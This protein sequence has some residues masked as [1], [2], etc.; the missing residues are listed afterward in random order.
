[1]FVC[2]LIFSCK[3]CGENMIFDIASQSAS[4]PGKYGAIKQ[5]RAFIGYRISVG[6]K[7]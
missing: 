1:M 5:A 2:A 4:S 3:K 7:A 6:E